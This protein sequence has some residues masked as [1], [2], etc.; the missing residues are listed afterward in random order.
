MRSGDKADICKNHVG[1]CG[2]SLRRAGVMSKPMTATSGVSQSQR[3]AN[4]QSLP[5][6]LVQRATSSYRLKSPPVSTLT[7]TGA[8]LHSH[9]SLP[10]YHQRLQQPTS[11]VTSSAGATSTSKARC[12]ECSLCGKRF[13]VSQQTHMHSTK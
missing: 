3:C 7:A 9:A 13:K 8:Q 10:G 1:G 5:L 6:N 4:S 2:M 12:F 11:L